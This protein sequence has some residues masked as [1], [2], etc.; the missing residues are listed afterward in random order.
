M[1]RMCGS[2]HSDFPRLESN[3]TKWNEIYTHT[4]TLLRRCFVLS[5]HPQ[6]HSSSS[7]SSS[8][9]HLASYVILFHS[10]Y[11][12]RT[13]VS[14]SECASHHA[15]LFLAVC[16]YVYNV[17][18]VCV[19]RYYHSSSCKNIFM[20]RRIIHNFTRLAH[21]S[22]Y[23]FAIAKTS[24]A[25]SARKHTFWWL[26][27]KLLLLLC[28]RHRCC[29]HFILPHTY[30]LIHTHTNTNT[31]FTSS[32]S[33]WL[34][35]CHCH[36]S[37]AIAFCIVFTWFCLVLFCFVLFSICRCAICLTHTHSMRG[38]FM[39]LKNE[40]VVIRIVTKNFQFTISRASRAC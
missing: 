8:L 19:L 20:R 28:N 10:R 38:V 6:F 34:R 18:V 7:S 27:L 22:E 24:D 2:S 37:I 29:R 11:L 4:H 33:F 23:I 14:L 39:A 21:M 12:F 16:D 13:V 30:L 1:L 25:S 15:S 5:C 36:C 17:C 40:L 3:K 9:H 31:I 32:S 26:L 35:A